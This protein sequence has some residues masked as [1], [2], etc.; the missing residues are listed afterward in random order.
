MMKRLAKVILGIA[1]IAI[2]CLLVA[3]SGMFLYGVNN[4]GPMMS[5]GAVLLSLMVWCFAAPLLTIFFRQRLSDA[6]Q[7]ALVGSPVAIFLAL[8]I[9]PA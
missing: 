1:D 5:G 2:G 9:I 6:W 8:M 3:L 7:F 4:T